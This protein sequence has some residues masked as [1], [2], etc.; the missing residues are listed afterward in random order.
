MGL[1]QLDPIEVANFGPG[2]TKKPL[3]REVHL[4][5][6]ITAR[7]TIN[8]LILRVL[9]EYPATWS[10]TPPGWAAAFEQLTSLHEAFIH[11]KA[12]VDMGGKTER[13]NHEAG[14]QQDSALA[15]EQAQK[16]LLTEW[17]IQQSVDALRQNPS[18]LQLCARLIL[19]GA[20]VWAKAIETRRVLA[21]GVNSAT[22]EGKAYA[23]A[24]F[25]EKA[26]E[27]FDAPLVL[28]P[29]DS[30]TLQIELV[31]PGKLTEPPE[32]PSVNVVTP[33]IFALP[34]IALDYEAERAPP[35]N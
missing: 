8:G 23:E 27:R 28:M 12:I 26:E 15:A 14:I 13:E 9:A 21:G 32:G 34:Y 24:A 19:S 6:P 10:S 35:V 18:P 3:V 5:P 7:W 11:A 2:L 17:G 1:Q 20:L 31:G 30:L 29:G 22:N 16:A 4:K 25:V 33:S